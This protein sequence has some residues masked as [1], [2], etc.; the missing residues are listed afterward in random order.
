[1]DTVVW[2]SGYAQLYLLMNTE[3]LHKDVERLAGD[4]CYQ[5]YGKQIGALN[6]I[7]LQRLV[8]T[9]ERGFDLPRA[10][11]LLYMGRMFPEKNYQRLVGWAE[12][13]WRTGKGASLAEA[14]DSKVVVLS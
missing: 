7:M 8:W 6:E 14:R 5:A 4:D 2:L 10:Y 1:M 11:E 12:R 13:E 3:L 9:M